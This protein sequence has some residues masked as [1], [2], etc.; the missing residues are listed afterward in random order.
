MKGIGRIFN[1]MGK[2]KSRWSRMVTELH[3]HFQT[4]ILL[5]VTNDWRDSTPNAKEGP[6]R[7]SPIGPHCA[8]CP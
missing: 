3:L 6:L 2:Y 8:V 1:M 7:P 5:H 4:V